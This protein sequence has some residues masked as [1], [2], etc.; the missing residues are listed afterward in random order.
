[1]YLNNSAKGTH[2]CISTKTLNTFML[3]TATVVPTTRKGERIIA[4]HGNTGYTN[5]TQRNVPRTVPVLLL[6]S[7]TDSSEMTFC[8]LYV[9]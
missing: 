9:T 3:L 5:A 1:M 6:Y 2:W 8:P 4:L 7:F